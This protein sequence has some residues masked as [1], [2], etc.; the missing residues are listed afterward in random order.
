[1][2]T[3]CMKGFPLVCLAAI[4]LSVQPAYAQVANC[5]FSSSPSVAVV[6]GKT[7][8][9]IGFSFSFDERVCALTA[10]GSGACEAEEGS[11]T[12]FNLE[13]APRNYIEALKY[14]TYE[15]GLIVIYTITDDESGTSFVKRLD[16]QSLRTHW[17][18]PIRGFNAGPPLREGSDLYVSAI[19]FVGKLD[20]EEGTYHWSH[21][22]LYRSPSM[23][24]AFGKPE[25][26]EGV[27]YFPD[28]RKPALRVKVNDETGTLLE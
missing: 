28:S 13:L 24:N 2:T 1:M 8:I 23:F 3:R 25:V 17:E 21:R 4:A 19:G 12:T 16:G 10:G 22:G 14:L 5:S 27:V 6:C 15:G 26:N 9:A 18:L 7:P 11:W 20:L